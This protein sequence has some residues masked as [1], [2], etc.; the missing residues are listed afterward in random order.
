MR[1]NAVAVMVGVLLLVAALAT[2]SDVRDIAVIL[3]SAGKVEVGSS[4]S[5]QGWRPGVRGTRLNSG[6]RVRTGGNSMAT[7]IFTDDKSL[8]KIRSDTEIS[9]QGER[10]AGTVSK[11]L[12]VD[13]GELWAKITKGGGGYRI[14]TPSG[15]AAV[16]G[17]EFYLLVSED[18]AATAIV[19]DGLVELINSLGSVLV[20]SGQTGTMQRESAP[21]SSDS[22]AIPDW[23]GEN[24]G[25]TGEEGMLRIEFQDESGA[26]RYLLIRYE[27]R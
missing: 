9:L 12:T 10:Q 13:V 11:R 27:Q 7:L 4:T 22:Q 20:G 14:E 25:V 15:V 2:A 8:L 24:V 21:T 26:K 23:G 19:L 16:K 17:T 18:G 6:N 1:R 3:K 5:S